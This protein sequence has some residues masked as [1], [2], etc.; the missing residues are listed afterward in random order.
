M[1]KTFCDKID[2]KISVI[3]FCF[4]VLF[5]GVSQRGEVKGTAK[6]FCKNIVSK[7]F[8]KKNDKN[9]KTDFSSVLFI[10]RFWAFLGEVEGSSK[11]P[12]IWF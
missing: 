2:K 3:D 1:S 6:T 4:F 7:S 9:S 10:S 8:Y 12:S 11:T 5:L